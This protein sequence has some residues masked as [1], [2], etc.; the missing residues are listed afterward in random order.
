MANSLENCCYRVIAG[1]EMAREKFID[2]NCESG[3]IEILKTN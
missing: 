1:Q 2:F 3:K